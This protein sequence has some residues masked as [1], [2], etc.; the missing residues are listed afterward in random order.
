MPLSSADLEDLRRAREL[1]ENPGTA[2][3]ITNVLGTPVEKAFE[4]LPR[5]LTR[6]VNHSTRA[7]LRGALSVGCASFSSRRIR[8]SRDATHKVLVATSGA[9]GGVFGIAGLPI[10]LPISTAIM[11]RSIADVARSEGEDL[12]SR[13]AREA[14]IH[15][16]ALGGRATSDDAAETG[17]FAVRAVLART[18]GEAAEFVA[19]RGIVQEG[20]PV[21]VRLLAGF[22][23]RSSIVVSEKALLQFLPLV[24]AAGGAGINLLFIAHFQRMARGHFIVRRLERTYGREA[25][26]RA[27]EGRVSV[28]VAPP[29][30]LSQSG[31]ASAAKREPPRLA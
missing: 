2:M 28:V 1:L 15:V 22:A 26:R 16:F 30:L 6:I 17:Y 8:R 19:E 11:L 29:L 31:V 25:V 3:K 14:C 24:G 20:A 10:E 9:I 27:Y 23:S 12:A 4:I 21:L 13:E 18:V 5:W 7:L